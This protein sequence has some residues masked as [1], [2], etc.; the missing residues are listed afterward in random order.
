MPP[1]AS[2]RRILDESRTLRRYHEA[3]CL[4]M[5]ILVQK[6]LVAHCVGLHTAQVGCCQ[7]SL[8]LFGSARPEHQFQLI[9]ENHTILVPAG[10]GC[11]ALI[12]REIVPPDRL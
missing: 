10:P 12:L 11:E 6:A 5:R 7:K 3:D 8:P 9:A 2:L 4:G 1:V